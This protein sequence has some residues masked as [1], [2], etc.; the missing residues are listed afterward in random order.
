VTPS[1]ENS[2]FL[3][4]ALVAAALTLGPRLAGAVRAATVPIPQ[5]VFDYAALHARVA[6]GAPGARV[7]AL[8]A[9]GE[10]AVDSLMVQ[11]RGA[12]RSRMEA[13]DSVN[14]V[15]AQS[16]MPGFA[17]AR[18]EMV[19]GAPRVARFAALARAHG[20]RA[21]RAFFAALAATYGGDDST[22]GAFWPDYVAQQTDYGGCTR[23]GTGRLVEAYAR[24]SLYRSAHRFRYTHA[25]RAELARVEEALTRSTCACGDRADVTRELT[26]FVRR[27][28]S[29][30]LA[31]QVRARLR[32]VRA[33]RSGM[34]FRCNSG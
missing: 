19:G 16:L 25:V 15:R 21:D 6:D 31:T 9:L 13:M 32:S 8:Y 3:A 24:W 22:A 26:A 4:L 20:D 34:R 12:K 30:T 29:T 17:L 7:E 33:G 14:F 2:R 1:P 11:A 18:E 23:Y 27:F 5:V 10:R 28:P